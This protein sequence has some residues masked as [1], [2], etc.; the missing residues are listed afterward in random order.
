[1]KN[2]WE[3]LLGLFTFLFLL[4]CV[5]W[6]INLKSIPVSTKKE[7]KT[8]LNT[9]PC[10]NENRL[11]GV[12]ELFKK[13]GAS[14]EEIKILTQNGIENI[15]VTKKGKTNQTVLIG[16][17]FDKTSF[18]CGAIDNWTGIV[19]ITHLFRRIKEIETEK[20]YQFVAFG[21]EELGLLGSKAFV[22][23]IPPKELNRYCAM[24]NFDS[25]GFNEPKALANA[26]DLNLI[27]LAKNTGLEMDFKFSVSF[28]QNADADSSSFNKMGIPAITFHGLSDDWP[29]YLHN[30]SDQINNVDIESVKKGYDFALKYLRKVDEKECQIFR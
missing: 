14:E 9:V 27:E 8:D 21:K 25:F 19:L 24:I 15:L 23:E 22:R 13:N 3:K 5:V 7:L 6:I 12:V 30:S 10:K 20:T 28:Y 2:H 16:A 11:K 18:G 1:M 17:H 29:N 26:S 4:F